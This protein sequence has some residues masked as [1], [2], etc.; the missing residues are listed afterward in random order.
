MPPSAWNV[1]LRNLHGSSA[2]GIDLLRDR[3]RPPSASTASTSTASENDKRAGIVIAVARHSVRHFAEHSL[4]VDTVTAI[5]FVSPLPS[6]AKWLLLCFMGL[7]PAVCHRHRVDVH[8][9]WYVFI[10]LNLG[11]SSTMGLIRAVGSRCHEGVNRRPWAGF[12]TFAAL[13]HAWAF[14]LESDLW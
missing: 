6:V 13:S 4:A 7:A 10:F 11:F 1:S 8:L 3:I 5:A 12:Q 2:S 14:R 9:T